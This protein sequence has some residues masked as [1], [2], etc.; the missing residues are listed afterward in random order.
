MSFPQSKLGQICTYNTTP[1]LAQ[2]SMLIFNPNWHNS[3]SYKYDFW[4]QLQYVA[5]DTYKSLEMIAL[6]DKLYLII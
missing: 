1:N 4:K 5:L 2:V 6:Y 3:A